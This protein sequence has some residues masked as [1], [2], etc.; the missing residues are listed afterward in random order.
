MKLETL[1][2]IIAHI[3]VLIGISFVIYLIWS[4]IK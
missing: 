2:V 4:L 3:G 1:T